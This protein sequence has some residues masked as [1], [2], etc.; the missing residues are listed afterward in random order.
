MP[1]T[2]RTSPSPVDETQGSWLN[3]SDAS[4]MEGPYSTLR[5]MGPGTNPTPLNYSPSSTSRTTPRPRAFPDGSSTPS[6]APPQPSTLF[7][8]LPRPPLT[9]DSR[10]SSSATA[11]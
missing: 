1:A 6:P 10:R 3:G 9:G 8:P 7:A 4:P 11:P 5:T 2:S